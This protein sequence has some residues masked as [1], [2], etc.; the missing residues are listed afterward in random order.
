MAATTGDTAESVDGDAQA[1]LIQ[2]HAEECLRRML[3]QSSSRL[4]VQALDD[5]G[6]PQRDIDR[7]KARMMPKGRKRER[8]IWGSNKITSAGRSL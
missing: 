3:G 2:T 4:G 8:E 1:D 5:L 7:M 6:L